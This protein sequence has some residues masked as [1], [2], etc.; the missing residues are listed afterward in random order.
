M[1]KRIKELYTVGIGNERT[2]R[3]EAVSM[4]VSVYLLAWLLRA[5][6]VGEVSAGRPSQTLH[7]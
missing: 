6:R 4:L 1:P 2:V 5:T 7:M 3:L